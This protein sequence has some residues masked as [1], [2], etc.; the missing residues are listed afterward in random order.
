MKDVSCEVI[1]DVALGNIG[2]RPVTKP[3]RTINDF[4]VFPGKIRHFGPLKNILPI[5]RTSEMHLDSGLLCIL[6]KSFKMS[7]C[8]GRYGFTPGAYF[9]SFRRNPIVDFFQL[10]E[11][12]GL[13][14]ADIKTNSGFLKYSFSV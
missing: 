5:D 9:L 4:V 2:I 12:V 6:F 3:P 8:N 11:K 10:F 14:M 1:L 7:R 13:F